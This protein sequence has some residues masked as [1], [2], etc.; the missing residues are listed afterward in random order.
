MTAAPGRIDPQTIAVGIVGGIFSGMLG[1]GGGI[2]MVPLLV[3][4]MGHTQRSAHATSLSAIIPIAVVGV[5][6]YALAD[7]IHY[8]L[9]LALAVGSILGAR[10]GAGALTRLSE[11]WLKALFGLLLLGVAASMVV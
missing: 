1:V 6:G 5:A 4:W 7:E 3:L 2:V 11:R 8:G 9:A 10:V